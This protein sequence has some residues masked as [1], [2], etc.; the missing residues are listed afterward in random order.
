MHH[1]FSWGFRFKLFTG[2]VIDLIYFSWRKTLISFY[3][4]TRYI[5][6]LENDFIITKPIFYWQNEKM[7]TDCWGNDFYLLWS[8][9]WHA[10]P[11]HNLGNLLFFFRQSSLYISFERCW[12]NVPGSSPYPM[13]IIDSSLNITFIQL[14]TPWLFFLSPL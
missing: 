6:I 3:S 8:F 5:I 10:T 13:Q 1:K 2:Y 12:R 14:S 9:K 4:M 7:C 11:Y